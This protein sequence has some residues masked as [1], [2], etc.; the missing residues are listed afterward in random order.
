MIPASSWLY[1]RKAKS[2]NIKISFF[3]IV[4]TQA[5]YF[6]E[7]FVAM[8]SSR[9]KLTEENRTPELS[10]HARRPIPIAK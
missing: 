4:F 7:A 10:W 2:S 5:R 9:K 1:C 3:V 6:P 8:A